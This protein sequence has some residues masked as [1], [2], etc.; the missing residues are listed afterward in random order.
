MDPEDRGKG[1]WDGEGERNTLLSKVDQDQTFE[2]EVID[3][4]VYTVQGWWCLDMLASRHG[5]VGNLGSVGSNL[6]VTGR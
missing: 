5:D 3:R 6:K 2:F 1:V 4:R